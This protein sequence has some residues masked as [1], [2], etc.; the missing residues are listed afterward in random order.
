MLFLSILL[1]A[2]TG[3]QKTLNEDE[4]LEETE[5]V[6]NVTGITH[7]PFMRNSLDESCSVL[8]YYRVSE[9]KIENH[10][11]QTSMDEMFGNI[12]DK[13]KFGEHK[14]FF[15][16]HK[17]N[18]TSFDENGIAEF[19]KIS[20]T[21]CY[22]LSIVVDETTKP[23]QNILL[24]RCVG[25]FEL[26]V[27]EALPDN[28]NTMDFTISGGS[29]KLDAKTGKGSNIEEQ[30]KTIQIP[31]K[32]LG[33]T[34]CTFS[35]F[36]FLPEQRCEVNVTATAKDENGKIIAQRTFSNVEMELNYITRFSGK[37]FSDES[38][39]KISVNPEWGGINATPF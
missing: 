19:D 27:T 24:N 28:L 32:N 2:M 20:D 23:A 31:A 38:N 26:V 7:E 25:K 21:F 8:D 37:F 30:Q 10:V 12:S 36:L 3:C 14:L 17:T 39:Y 22:Y 35:S 18:I 1:I 29:V 33:T 16:G 15:I 13:L 34:N 5:L 6:F 9:G 4:F 11:T